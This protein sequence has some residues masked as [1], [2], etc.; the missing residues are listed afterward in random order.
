M[1][2]PQKGNVRLA[3]PRDRQTEKKAEK[4]RGGCD[5]AGQLNEP[6]C[7]KELRQGRRGG[8][9]VEGPRL[10]R[11]WLPVGHVGATHRGE[12]KKQA[13]K[14]LKSEELSLAPRLEA[15]R[16]EPEKTKC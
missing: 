13:Q 10:V 3:L 11:V 16:R 4:R 5:R 8:G 9:K 6:R 1:F 12:G 14:K 7:R 15:K 2:A